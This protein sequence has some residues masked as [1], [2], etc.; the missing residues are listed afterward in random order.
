L[1]QGQDNH[2]FELSQIASF[3]D[4]FNSS[5]E[6]STLQRLFNREGLD[7]T[8]VQPTANGKVKAIADITA[9]CWVTRLLV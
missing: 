3:H 7:A 4:L 9:Q 2:Q 6:M 5:E 1:D 8:F